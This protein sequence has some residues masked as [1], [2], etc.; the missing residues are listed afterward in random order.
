MFY[1]YKLFDY[2]KVYYKEVWLYCGQMDVPKAQIRLPDWF[3]R[4]FRACHGGVNHTCSCIQ[5]S[6]WLP[7]PTSA[8]LSTVS[9]DCW[10]CPVKCS[11][12]CLRLR[13]TLI[14]ASSSL[15][16]CFWARSNQGIG[17]VLRGNHVSNIFFL[18]VT[19]MPGLGPL[20]P[21][22]FQAELDP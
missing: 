2:S 7:R 10:H 6:Y 4:R 20:R 21:K 12:L 8:L 3:L 1:R 15:W 9:R 11:F 17:V 22:A 13:A 16:G 14:P 18:G 5:S 19:S